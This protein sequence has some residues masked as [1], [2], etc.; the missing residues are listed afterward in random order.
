MK[1]MRKSEKEELVNGYQLMVDWE[2]VAGFLAS[3]PDYSLS[4]LKVNG[5]IGD[6]RLHNKYSQ[7]SGTEQSKYKEW[8]SLI[9]IHV[10]L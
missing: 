3:L 10:R 4:K 5:A 2:I 7:N 8:N 1:K 9:T 6:R